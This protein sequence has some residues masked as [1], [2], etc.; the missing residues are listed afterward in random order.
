[1]LHLLST[2]QLEQIKREA[3]VQALIWA[4]WEDLFDVQRE[5]ESHG[6]DISVITNA[7]GNDARTI[8]E[9]E[10]RR[11]SLAE[12]R[13]NW[14]VKH[15]DFGPVIDKRHEATCPVPIDKKIKYWLSGKTVTKTIADPHGLRFFAGDKQVL[16]VVGDG[17]VYGSVAS[18]SAAIELIRPLFEG[19]V[20]E[21]D[22]IP[23]TTSAIEVARSRNG[24]WAY[25]TS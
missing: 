4:F 6:V 23:V 2:K 17:I 25:M 19:L 10:E 12:L 24:H 9:R 5:W 8:I 7:R 13:S 14:G 20:I 21:V 15:T 16:A 22:N 11:S 18:Y 3:A 1:M